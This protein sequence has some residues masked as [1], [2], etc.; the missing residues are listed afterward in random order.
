MAGRGM[1]VNLTSV[2]KFR[3][4]V[5]DTVTKL[6]EQLRETDNAITTVAEGWKDDIF[7]NFR[8]DFSEDKKK[9]EPLC[10]KLE[11][12]QKLLHQTEKRIENYLSSYK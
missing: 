9:I 10:K 8:D 4:E 5:G 7:K 6:R 3:K 1:D 2:K 11:E 12:Y